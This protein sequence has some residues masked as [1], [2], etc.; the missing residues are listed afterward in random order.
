MKAKVK[1]L[2]VS[3]FMALFSVQAYSQGKGVEAMLQDPQKQEQIFSTIMKDEQLLDKFMN[4]MMKN[5]ADDSSMAM[6]KM[7]KSMMGDKEMMG[8]M[9]D[10][11]EMMKMMMKTMMNKAENDSSMCRMMGN[12]MMNDDHMKSM[13][14][15]KNMKGRMNNGKAMK[16]EDHME[17]HKDQN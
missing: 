17:M 1:F 14:N 3:G 13:M 10:D 16:E 6:M 4:R 7:C 2:I 11:P 12:M 15:G 5:G 8:R 9:M